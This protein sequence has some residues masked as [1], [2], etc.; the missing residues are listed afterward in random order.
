MLTSSTNGLLGESTTF[1]GVI[2]SLIVICLA[3]SHSNFI[4]VAL[5]DYSKLIEG[6]FNYLKSICNFDSIIGSDD[7]KKLKKFTTDLSDDKPYTKKVSEYVK[8]K[9]QALEFEI[10]VKSQVLTSSYFEPVNKISQKIENSREPLFAPYYTMI[11]L[12]LIFIGDEILREFGDNP[13]VNNTVMVT[14]TTFIVLSA[15]FWIFLWLAFYAGY[16]DVGQEH[17]ETKQNKWEK[18]IS[19]ALGKGHSLL[20]SVDGLSETSM[21]KYCLHTFI[22]IIISLVMYCFTAIP[23]SKASETLCSLIGWI[24]I[25]VCVPLFIMTDYRVKHHI[26]TDKNYNYGFLLKHL[27]IMAIGSVIIG[28]IT[29]LEPT[30]R[31]YLLSHITGSPTHFWWKA[32]ATVFIITNAFILPLIIPY[33]GRKKILGDLKEMVKKADE[34][35]QNAHKELEPRLTELCRRLQQE[36]H[37]AEKP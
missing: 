28:C 12:M 16:Q 17:I 11:M 22:W 6:K 25:G 1:F 31:T 24:A 10:S 27:C 9:A 26:N 13:I 29:I 35:E 4:W 3:A 20:K 8:T 32:S 14:L 18:A 15:I 37:Q 23:L 34:A 7:Y 33:Y 36:T 2:I 5:N 19:S 21:G 30:L